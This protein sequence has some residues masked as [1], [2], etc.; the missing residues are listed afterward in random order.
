MNENQIG[1]EVVEAAR[2][3]PAGRPDL[4]VTEVSLRLPWP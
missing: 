2:K 1:K 3:M 4:S